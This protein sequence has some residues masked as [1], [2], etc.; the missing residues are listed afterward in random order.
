MEYWAEAFRAA[1]IG[2]DPRA[3]GVG[4]DELIDLRGSKS[5][6]RLR[7]R[8]TAGFAALQE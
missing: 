3:V 4:Q 2:I 7:G 1:G 5:N 6:N 8:V